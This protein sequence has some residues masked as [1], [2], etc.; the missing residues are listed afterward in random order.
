[1]ALF[2]TKEQGTTLKHG[3]F[4]Q[5]HFLWAC[6]CDHCNNISLKHNIDPGIAAQNAKDEGFI[7]VAVN[8]VAPMFWLCKDCQN[9]SNKRYCNKNETH[10]I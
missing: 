2:Q 6:Q 7:A 5:Y 9:T 8:K 1:M 3:K 10:T 4:L